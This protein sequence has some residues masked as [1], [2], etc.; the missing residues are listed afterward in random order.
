MV[1]SLLA[2]RTQGTEN[3]HITDRAVHPP[4]PCRRMTGVLSSFINQSWPQK[5]ISKRDQIAAQ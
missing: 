3:Q 5:G 4:T 2:A 1:P